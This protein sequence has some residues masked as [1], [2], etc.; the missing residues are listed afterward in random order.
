VRFFAS[1]LSLILA[2]CGAGHLIESLPEPGIPAD[3]SEPN[4]RQIIADNIAAVFP[5]PDGLGNLEVSAVRPVNHLRGP[6]WLACLKIHAD[7]V[8]QEY[9]LLI[10][11][12]KV[13]D[14]RT[15]VV[16]DR[17]KQ[18]AYQPFDLASFKQQKKAGR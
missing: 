12:D 14:Q 15:G 2:G 18:Q 16:M 7:E 6:A 4:Y 5:N 3:L 10:Q 13:I 9:A 8:P 17:C 11:G 1:A